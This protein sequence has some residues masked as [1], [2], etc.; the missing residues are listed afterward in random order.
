MDWGS[1]LKVQGHPR[2]PAARQ[3]YPPS[4]GEVEQIEGSTTTRDLNVKF[5]PMDLWLRLDFFL[6]EKL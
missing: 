5:L 1:P 3:Q 4:V 2:M 6:L